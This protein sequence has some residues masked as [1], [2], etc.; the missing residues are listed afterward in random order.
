MSELETVVYLKVKPCKEPLWLSFLR[1]AQVCTGWCVW[2]PGLGVWRGS[3][4]KEG[5]FHERCL[6]MKAKPLT[7]V[8]RG[9]DLNPGLKEGLCWKNSRPPYAEIG[10]WDFF[11]LHLVLGWNSWKSTERNVSELNDGRKKK[12]LK[13]T[14]ESWKALIWRWRLKSSRRRMFLDWPWRSGL[15]SL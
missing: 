4:H 5:V 15:H 13:G 8:P 9:Y 14:L 3:H 2:T 7:C 10:Q 1:D 11:N 12:K 6:W